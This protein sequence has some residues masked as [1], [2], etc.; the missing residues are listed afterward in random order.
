MLFDH[1]WHGTTPPRHPLVLGQVIRAFRLGAL[2]VLVP[3]RALPGGPLAGTL[4]GSC[5]HGAA[6]PRAADDTA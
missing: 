6:H 5:A 3:G 2:P 1:R 4:T